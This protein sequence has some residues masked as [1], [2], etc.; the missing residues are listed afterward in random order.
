MSASGVRARK[1]T[2]VTSG[3]A[4]ETRRSYPTRLKVEALLQELRLK[5]SSSSESRGKRSGQ[6][7]SGNSFDVEKVGQPLREVL[8]KPLVN[9][10]FRGRKE[11]MPHGGD[12][13]EVSIR[14]SVASGSGL[15]A[16]MVVRFVVLRGFT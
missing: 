7:S 6:P 15:M 8:P 1:R 13:V 3:A 16:V 4:K 12:I 2:S 10:G 11:L 9:G 5:Q 14:F